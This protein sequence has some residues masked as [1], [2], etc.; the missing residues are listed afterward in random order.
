MWDDPEPLLRPAPYA[1]VAWP[2]SVRVKLSPRS[3]PASVDLTALL[4]RRET[5]REFG[6]DV[7]D[8]SLGE[9]LW[10]ACRSRGSR[11]SP[12]GFDQ[13]SRPHPSAG[14]AHPIHVLVARDGATWSR[15]DPTDHAIVEIPGLESN[16]AAVRAAA[17]MLVPVDRGIILALVAEPGKSAAKYAHPQSLV[18]RDAGVVIGYMSVV[19]EALRMP[20]CPLGITGDPHL[21]DIHGPQAGLHGAGLAVLG[22]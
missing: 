1:P 18:W 5:R 2:G 13:E 16:A 4:E 19:A 21:A 11:P 10:L 17:S 20:F 3:G 14:A 12:Y 7:R 9:F 15:Y 22:G 6:R 8:D